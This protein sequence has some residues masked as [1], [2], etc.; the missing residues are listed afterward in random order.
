MNLNKY[1]QSDYN[2]YFNKCNN[3]KINNKKFFS[4]STFIGLFCV[5]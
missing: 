1:P 4:Q 5:R 3:N 2:I